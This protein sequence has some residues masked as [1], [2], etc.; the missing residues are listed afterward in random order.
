MYFESHESKNCN[1]FII[2]GGYKEVKITPTAKTQA[3]LGTNGSGKS[4]LLKIGWCPL[5]PDPSDY[6]KPGSWAT[7][8]LHHGKRFQLS[9][10]FEDKNSY[11]FILDGVELNLARNITTQLQLT[12]EHLDYDRELHEL[13]TGEIIFTK[14]TANERRDWIARLSM[15]DFGFAFRKYNEYKKEKNASTIIAKH[16]QGR[17]NEEREKLLAPED[18]AAMRARVAELR[19]TLDMLVREPKSGAKAVNEHELADEFNAVIHDIKSI[20]RTEYPPVSDCEQSFEEQHTVVC[21]ELQI[22]K[23]ELNVRGER[24][25]SCE[26]KLRRVEALMDNDPD[27]LKATQDKLEQA[28]SDIPERSIDI[29]PS[30]LIPADAVLLELRAA[31]GNVPAEYTSPAEV[32]ALQEEA[33]QRRVKLGRVSSLLEDINRQIGHIENCQVVACPA[34]NHEFKPGVEP[35]VLEALQTRVNSGETLS[36]TLVDEL[37]GTDEKLSEMQ[38]GLNCY[39]LL[40]SVRQRHQTQYPGL[41]TFIDQCGGLREGRKLFTKLGIYAREVTYVQD[42]SKILVRLEAVRAALDQY[43]RESGDHSAVKLDYSVAVGEYE[44]VREKLSELNHRRNYLERCLAKN[45]EY[46]MMANNGEIWYSALRSKFIDYCNHQG[47]VMLEELIEKT[48][49]TLGVHEHA[50][51]E[52]EWNEEIV[53]DLQKQF[54]QAKVNE[55]AYGI[56]TEAMSPKTGLIADQIGDQIGALVDGMNQMI[57]RVWGYP[58]YI[59]MSEVTD[60]GVDYKFPIVTNGRTRSDVKYGSASIVSIVDQAFRLVAYYCL[61]L[62]GYPLFLDEMGNDFDETHRQNLTTLV[63]ELVDNDKF[64]QVF[65]I[66]HQLETQTAFPNSQTIILDDSN[67]EYNHPY[68][69]HVEFA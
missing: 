2:G 44:A 9:A 23:G 29:H 19:E 22:L 41:F 15:V 46:T 57:K 37:N 33:Y 51:Q 55:A 11:S 58:L 14:M 26:Q 66:N 3:V 60:A 4:S 8:V 12:K 49:S 34:C 28:V 47:D 63:K 36:K 5:P 25:S 56:L 38:A 21:N 53:K 18:M 67:I 50:L 16:M 69:T 20:L 65:M 27:E 52:N 7:V 13:L 30:L 40:E 35:G 61:K 31:L 64:S 45:A 32:M 59:K 1:R 10:K 43:N 6:D 48:I 62:N 42:R 39:N 17:L 68:N 24:V 54:D